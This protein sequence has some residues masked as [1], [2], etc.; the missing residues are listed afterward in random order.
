MID[1]LVT[2]LLL[3]LAKFFFP[4]EKKAGINAKKE[5]D[6]DTNSAAFFFSSSPLADD[7][8]SDPVNAEYYHDGGPDW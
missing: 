7:I 8:E 5:S 6:I 2:W 1:V 3:E 4:E